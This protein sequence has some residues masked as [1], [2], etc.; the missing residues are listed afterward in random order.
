LPSSSPTLQCHDH[1]RYRSPINNLTCSDHA[2]TD[3]IQWRALGLNTTELADLVNNCPVSCEIPCDSFLQFQISVSYR[4]SNVPGLLDAESTRRLEEMSFD[5]LTEFVRTANPDVIFELDEVEMAFQTEIVPELPQKRRKLSLSEQSL[6]ISVVFRGFTIGMTSDYVTQKLVLGIDD[7][8]FTLIL[9]GS[10]VSYF[11]IA[12]AS[13]AT[14]VD[15]SAYVTRI[16]NGKERGASTATVVVFSLVSVSIL[17]LGV[18]SIFYHRRSGK[19]VP[20]PWDPP[21]KQVE[22]RDLGSPKSWGRSSHPGSPIPFT[23]APTATTSNVQGGLLGLIASMSL[24]RSRSSTSVD[25]SSSDTSGDATV[26][27]TNGPLVSPMSDGSAKSVPKAHPL[28]RIIPPM[29]VIENIDEA[30]DM[31]N[32]RG[33][34]QQEEPVGRDMLP[35]RRVGASTAFLAALSECRKPHPHTPNTFA[36]ML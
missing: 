36:G 29:I 13:S 33:S 10:G 35:S 23:E 1:I 27:P 25:A 22:G 8:E 7:P 34:D 16:D 9:R 30:N 19:W 14:E 11:A 5:F 6:S 2:G 3:C 17:M 18:G 20:V 32:I 28:A 21:L 12:K 24:S 15:R 26:V 31:P 4:L